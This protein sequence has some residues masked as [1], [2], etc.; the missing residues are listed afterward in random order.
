MIVLDANI[1][2]RMANRLDPQ[3]LQSRNAVFKTLRTHKLVIFPQTVFE[4]WAVATRAK[5]VNG[6][7][8]STEIAEQW[9]HHYR[10]MFPVL[11]DTNHL[12]DNWQAIVAQ[13]RVTGFRAHDARY[14]AAMACWSITQIMTY[15]AKHY[16]DYSVTIIDPA[17]V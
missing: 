4:F 13:Y 3:Y 12:L 9:V 17:T 6:L 16:M 14:V 10:R 7:G 11:S 8:L 5:A 1:L 15:N 2:V